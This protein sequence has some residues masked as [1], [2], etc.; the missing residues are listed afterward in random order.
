V[1]VRQ[2]MAKIF[3]D[4][5]LPAAARALIASDGPKG[6]NDLTSFQ[7]DILEALIVET[8]DPGVISAELTGKPLS[9]RQQFRAQQ[10]RSQLILNPSVQTLQRAGFG[11]K[12]SVQ[13]GSDASAVNS[14]NSTAYAAFTPAPTANH[15]GSAALDT[16]LGDIAASRTS[17]AFNGLAAQLDPVFQGPGITPFLRGQS[18]LV[19]AN[20]LPV[21]NLI[22][23]LNPQDH[24]PEITDVI[25]SSLEILG[26]LAAMGAAVLLLPEELTAGIVVGTG[27]AIFAGWSA[28]AVGVID[29]GTALDC[30][31]DGDPFDPDDVPGDEC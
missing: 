2:Q 30:D 27:L 10:I 29:L 4:P 7:K 5:A 28:V 12:F 13:L 14:S 20:F 31:H 16:A 22:A 6:R 3:S 26:G 19:L 11:L 1:L 21:G 24:D 23:L 15:G 25:K 18:P 8:S 17:A 9:L